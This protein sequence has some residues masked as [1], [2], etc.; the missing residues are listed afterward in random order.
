MRAVRVARLDILLC[1]G[2][3]W[4][5][6]RASVRSSV[7]SGLGRALLPQDCVLCGAA[8]GAWPLCPPCRADLPALPAQCP[9]CA[10]ASLDGSVCGACLRAAPPFDATHAAWRYEFPADRLVHALK[11]RA[12]LALAAFFGSVLAARFPPGAADLVVPMP[13]HRL[14]LAE[15][16]FNQAA[17]IA[18]HM[19]RATRTPF[20]PALAVRLRPTLPQSD[21]PHAERAGNVRGA[22]R[23]HADLRGR[24]VAVVD[25]VMTSGAT[26]AELARALKRAGAARVENWVVT[27]TLKHV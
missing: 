9:R 7:W 26:L 17:E 6:G 1:W 16:G 4:Q 24:R 19:A 10:D 18:R 22:F 15:R 3:A 2:G 20:A 21:L 8:S 14:R 11:F 27:R 13:L 25:D 12:R 5:S 23:C